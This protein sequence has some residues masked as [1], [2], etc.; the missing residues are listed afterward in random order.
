[1]LRGYSWFLQ[2]EIA[3]GSL[4]NHMRYWE[5]NQVPPG[6]LHTRQTPYRYAIS[7]VPE[8]CY[9]HHSLLV[10]VVS[11]SLTALMSLVVP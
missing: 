2:S 7:P 8:N 3:P 11:F 5:M 10:T 9:S 4:R 1:M 6:W